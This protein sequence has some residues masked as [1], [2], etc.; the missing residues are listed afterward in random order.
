MKKNTLSLYTAAA[1]LALA[2]SV[3][4]LSQNLTL[5]EI[6]VTATKRVEGLQELSLIHI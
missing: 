6:T 2:T 4:A 1:S 5:E 3:P